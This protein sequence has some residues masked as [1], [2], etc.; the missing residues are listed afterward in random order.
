MTTR[1]ST[2]AAP[3]AARWLTRRLAPSL[4]LLA[5]VASVPAQP[6][7]PARP[8][9]RVARAWPVMGTMLG[10]TVWGT[11]TAAMRRGV[12]AA[13][14]SVRLVDSLM[15]SYR[16]TS[17]ISRLN[18]AAG[19][20]PLPVSPQTLHV[21]RRAR[22]FWRLSGGRFDPTVGPLVRAWGFQG[23]SGRVPPRAE[24][25]SLRMLV[26]FGAVEIDSTAGTVRLPRAG[27]RLDLGG[28]AKGYALDLARRAL[29]D[30]RIT[31]GMVDLG[32][33]VLVFGR[34]PRGERWVIGIRHPRG[35]GR[36]L[37]TVTLDS[38]AV[39]TS[40][41]Y[42]HFYRIDGVRYGHLIDPTTGYPRRGV[43][44]ATA[45]GPRGDW[46][47]GLSAT[48]FL[49]GPARG[50]AIADSLPHV[51]GLWVLDGDADARA[52]VRTGDVV[53]SRRARAIFTPAPGVA[54]PE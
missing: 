3:I 10:V 26:D 47:D 23:D 1:R 22:L 42:E 5:A 45:I 54:T 7:Q 51:A 31:G 24:L 15:S 25:D 53:L 9:A 32:G 28:I 16:P 50:A 6:A 41:D 33:N 30:P 4:A 46:S 11:D 34:P 36:L 12:Y 27:M 21:L 49:V 18:A 19:G 20:A 13:R 43:M 17:E 37:G 52:E 44:A 8:P 48:L 2:G 35:D 14:D 39:A 40:G 29:R 38:G